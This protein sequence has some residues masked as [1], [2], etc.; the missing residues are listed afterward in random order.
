MATQITRIN[1]LDLQENIAIG[2]S[3]PFKGN[4]GPFNSTF[5]TQDQI[6]YNVINLLLTSKG[7]RVFNPEFGSDLKKVV[8]DPA[9]EDRE[10]RENIQNIVISSINAFIPEVEVINVDI[11]P[12]PDSNSLTITTSYKFKTSGIS[13]EVTIEFT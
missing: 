1:P 3:L 10:I 9:V 4:Y 13:D 7:E 5:S 6:K 12:N 8:F 11:T 2:I